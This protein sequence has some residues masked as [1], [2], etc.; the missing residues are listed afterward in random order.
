MIQIKQSESGCANYI[1]A[2]AAEGGVADKVVVLALARRVAVLAP[3]SLGAELL[4]A[5]AG[6]A[7]AALAAAV[8]RV[9][10]GLVVAV[11]L[12]LYLREHREFWKSD[13]GDEN[14]MLSSACMDSSQIVLEEL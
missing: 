2:D 3:V 6:V 7:G 13:G 5:R 1:P 11:A 8:H 12:A 10:G 4:A 9:A 14:E